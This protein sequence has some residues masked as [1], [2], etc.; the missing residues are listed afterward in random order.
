MQRLADPDIFVWLARGGSPT[1]AELDRA[2][3]V[4]ADRLCGS[5][6]DPI[7]RNEQERRQLALVEAWLQAR[8]YRPAPPGVRYNSMAPGTFAFRL[9][10]PIRRNDPEG[11]AHHVNI[12]VDAAV[13]PLTA[14]AGDFPLLIEAKSA[15][16]F[17]NTN[18]RRKEEAAKLQQLKAS[19][20]DGV[21]LVLFL[22]GYFGTDY[23]G[24]EAAEGMDWVW[25]HRMDDLS[26]CGL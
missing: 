2:A 14:S 26:G 25:E 22:C 21:R 5:A 6:A 9:N 24:Y 20:G 16:D 7:I 18:K 8:G 4:V 15:G 1:R 19:H 3:S 10:V 17:T 23:L 11:I 13:L 12:P